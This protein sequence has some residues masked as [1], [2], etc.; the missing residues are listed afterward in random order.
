MTLVCISI[1]FERKLYHVFMNLLER[2][3]LGSS[4]CLYFCCTID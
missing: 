1:I 2:M 4:V 3:N